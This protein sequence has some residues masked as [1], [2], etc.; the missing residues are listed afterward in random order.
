MF[1]DVEYKFNVAEHNF[2]PEENT[3]YHRRTDNLSRENGLILPHS[4]TFLYLF[5]I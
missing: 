4:S 2:L 5:N 1:N 3:S